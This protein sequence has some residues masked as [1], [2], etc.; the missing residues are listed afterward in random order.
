MLPDDLRIARL[1]SKT[2]GNHKA[3]VRVYASEDDQTPNRQLS[4]SFDKRTRKWDAETKGKET[5]E[6]A[7]SRDVCNFIP[8]K[9]MLSH[10]Y[11]LSAASSVGN[12]RFDDTYIDIINAAK[13]DISMGKN[14]DIRKK[15]LNKIE[16][17][18][19]GSTKY[20]PEK[21][22]FYLRQGNA[23]M[24]FNLV[25]EGMKKAGLLWL[26]VKNATLEKGSILFWDE[27][28]A[29]LN[30]TNIPIIAE[31]LLDL[32]KSG[33]QIFIATHDYVL[34]KYLDIFSKKRNEADRVHYYSFYKD[35]EADNIL[36]E[37][38]SD[39]TLLKNNSIIKSMVE[40]YKAEVLGT[41]DH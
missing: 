3:F 37:Q 10:S 29:N 8:A 1:V 15:L 38:E 33:V 5:W 41:N 30:P 11:Q 31:I 35:E 16:K 21:D 12:V 39:F 32:Q 6:K 2:S 17:M 14:P 26:L 40:V 19:K 23:Y 9:E 28:E 36:C 34:A 24:E 27:P 20:E 7:F 25:A 22:E 13:V 18:T 4:I